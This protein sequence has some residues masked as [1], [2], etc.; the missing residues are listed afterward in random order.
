MRADSRYADHQ[1]VP[2]RGKDG[3]VRN[4]ILA[5][6]PELL[7]FDY[8]LYSWRQDDRVDL[9]AFDFYGVEESWWLIGEA[10]PE[11][12]DWNSVPIGTIIRIPSV[13]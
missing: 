12:L 7:T 13:Q 3:R 11:I 4:T 1:I 8:S 6:E 5:K 10:N 9:V 2:L